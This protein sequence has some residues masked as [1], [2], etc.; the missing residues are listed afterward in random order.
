[1]V[2][3]VYFSN[4]ALHVLMLGEYMKMGNISI[5]FLNC[6]FLFCFLFSQRNP[7]RVSCLSLPFP[8]IWLNHKDSMIQN[9][10]L[11]IQGILVSY[12]YCI[13]NIS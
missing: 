11:H 13:G 1:M 7:L 3:L 12:F 9:D 2:K 5:S 8:Y 6:F 4:T 10:Q